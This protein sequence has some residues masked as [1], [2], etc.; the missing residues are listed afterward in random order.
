V[1]ELLDAID[2][3]LSSLHV[4]SSNGAAKT[5]VFQGCGELVGPLAVEG[6]DTLGQGEGS[7]ALA[8]EER[9]GQFV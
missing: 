8:V 3:L 4:S 2:E 9:L 5:G 7:L 6:S 1:V